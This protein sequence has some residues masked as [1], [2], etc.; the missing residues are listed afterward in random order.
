M[1]RK[2][3]GRSLDDVD[4]EKPEW[5]TLV[6]T[7]LHVSARTLDRTLRVLSRTREIALE[8]KVDWV[9]CLGD[10]WDARGTLNVRQLDAILDEF[11]RWMDAGIELV[12][13]PGNHDQVTVGGTIHGVRV[14][15][16]FPNVT[17]ATEVIELVDKKIAFLPWREQ[18]EEQ[19]K[20]FTELRGKDWTVFAHA[21]VQGATTNVHHVAPGR[22][23]LAT[24][25]KKCRAAYCG[26][27]HKS[28][29]LG[30]RAFYIGSPFQMNFGEIDDPPKG[31]ALI[32]SNKIDPE[33]IHLDGF[34]KHVRATLD[35]L[36]A[37]NE[38]DIV[39]LRVDT[40]LLGSED[41]A[42]AI[43]KI[44]ANDVR[45]VGVRASSDEIETAVSYTLDDAIA[46][47][48]RD[49]TPEASED[50]RDALITLAQN[51]LAEIPGSASVSPIDPQVALLGVDSKNFCALKGY[52]S[53]DLDDK[54]L[55][56]LRGPIGVGKT[57]LTD[58]I[59]WAL[60]GQTSPRKAGSHGASL[61]ADEVIH[62][63]ADE[64]SVSVR[65]RVGGQDVV[66]TRHKRRGSGA[67][68]A[69][70]GYEVEDGIA[71]HQS[72][73]NRLVGLD[74]AMWRACV[75]LGQGAVGS[76]V[77]DADKRRK[78][79]LASAFGLDVC[80]DAVKKV[81]G[82]LKPM[83]LRRDQVASE[84]QS[85]ERVLTTLKDTD[86]S[87]EVKS[88][89]ERRSASMTSEEDVIISAQRTIKDCDA[90][91]QV[92]DQWL[93]IKKQHEDRVTA[94][95]SQLATG[96]DNRLLEATREHGAILAEKAI[97]ER[98]LS[99][100][101][102][103][104]NTLLEKA[105]AP[106]SSCPTCGQEIDQ[107]VAVVKA[108]EMRLVVQG[109]S[110]SLESFSAK[111]MNVQSRIETIKRSGSAERQSVESQIAES[112]AS[113]EKCGQA[114]STLER[115][116]ANRAAAE[117][118]I[119]KAEAKIKETSGLVNP[120]RAEQAKV[121]TKLQKS[122]SALE[123]LSAEAESLDAQIESLEFWDRG[124]GPKGIPVR[125]LRAALS[126]LET[127]ANKFLSQLL[128]GRIFCKLS[129]EGDSLDVRFVESINGEA[130]DRRY[131]QLSG[132]QRRCAELAFAPFAIS[133][134]VFTRCGVS[135]PFLIIDELT[136]H[137]G[138]QEKPIVC[139]I[140]RN[141]NRSTILVI[142][143]DAAVQGEFDVVLDLSR[144]ETGV[145]IVRAT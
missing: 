101:N 127:H 62:D 27:Y 67:R 20:L 18:P 110:R 105:E 15:E 112:R 115:L 58:A 50:E 131:E 82:V 25:S 129:M 114:L 42:E 36:P 2:R 29:K 4:T 77:T 145:Q 12:M 136:T 38:N 111:T 109:L 76:F 70:G 91:I 118:Q 106:V 61:R 60:Y 81:R 71:D 133:E 65:L 52:V 53:L 124:F 30:D 107:S 56:M 16:A 19:S 85:E 10:F 119:S 48:V 103:E 33:M 1:A 134:L 104:L 28:Q 79:L 95:M 21:E 69:I 141:L 11:T 137:L 89:E 59:T 126:D 100:K 43:K 68:V 121:A 40:A 96:V 49:Q 41:V 8:R 57:A 46:E 24:I 86:F 55:V 6:F 14:F 117:Q 93:G 102:T 123:E 26:H 125:V 47:Y 75:A 45:V 5:R 132:G 128:H 32:T 23:S 97:V 99:F 92:G 88:W 9:T 22:V 64:T 35:E 80:P 120:F 74:H 84:S 140:L 83:R 98:D 72:V 63:E 78:E 142:D 37:T 90:H 94:L 3:K 135:V 138:Q 17:V 7:D 73:I 130:R 51:V 113:I 87:V 31:L 44:K 116:K 108:D 34:P 143:H 139:D 13:I 144:D 39:E 66:I 122:M 54:G